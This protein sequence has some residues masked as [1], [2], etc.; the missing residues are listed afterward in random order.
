MTFHHLLRRQPYD[1][2]IFPNN[3]SS[4]SPNR[5]LNDINHN[6]QEGGVCLLP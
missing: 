2:A 3:D 5:A 1:L 4:L 6:K